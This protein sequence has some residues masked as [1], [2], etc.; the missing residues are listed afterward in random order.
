[1]ENSLHNAWRSLLCVLAIFAVIVV[2]V[3]SRHKLSKWFLEEF[4]YF[5]QKHKECKLHCVIASVPSSDILCSTK[6]L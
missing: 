3:G 5:F 2:E 4:R 1:M 6:H